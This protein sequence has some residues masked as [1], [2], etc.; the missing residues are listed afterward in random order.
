[1]RLNNMINVPN[2][3]DGFPDSFRQHS[4]F[5][6]LEE[7][8]LKLY[9]HPAVNLER[10]EAIDN[11]VRA[12]LLFT[13]CFYGNLLGCLRGY[14]SAALPSHPFAVKEDGQFLH[15]ILSL[16]D[17]ELSTDNIPMKRV[18]IGPHY[19]A[20]LEAAQQAGINTEPVEILVRNA[21]T[22]H[23]GAQDGEHRANVRSVM[24]GE[25]FHTSC[26]DYM[27]LSEHC[28][29]TY[30]EALSTVGLRELSLSPAF[31]NLQLKIPNE[32]K[33]EAYR[34]F[35]KA[36]IELDDGKHGPIMKQ[37]LSLIP[38]I[39]DSINT[40]VKFYQV[41]LTVYDACLAAHPIY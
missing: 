8:T 5:D 26:T 4:R 1:M 40:M 17:E 6:R 7:V 32:S 2:L 20:M 35:L 19:V 27:V 37:A 36:H 3:L 24:V 34:H 25:G 38:N 11:M 16:A 22:E 13:V 21:R 41:R 29:N 12:S 30:Y 23:F 10:P 9:N 14:L 28:A 31:E 33:Y 18:S 15:L 39:G